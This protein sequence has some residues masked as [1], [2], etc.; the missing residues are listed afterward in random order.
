MVAGKNRMNKKRYEILFNQI[1]LHFI[2]MEKNKTIIQFF[3]WY[4]R[5][6]GR[7]WKQFKEAIPELVYMGFTAAWL[8]PAYKG[9]KGSRSEGYDVYD[10]YD[11]GEFDQKETVATGYGT[12]ADYIAACSAA[13]SAGLGIIVDV[14]LNHKGGADETEKIMVRKVDAANRNNFLSGPFE[15]EAFTRFT[16]PGRNKTYSDF[17]WDHRCFTGIDRLANGNKESAEENVIYSIINEYGEGWEKDVD[18]ANDNFD[19]LMFCDLEFRNPYVREELKKWIKWY[20]AKVPFQGVRL[21]AV[22][23]ISYAFLNE[24]IDYLRDELGPNMLVIGEYWLSDDLAILLK[25]SEDTE[26][27]M[28]LFD[29]P[30]HHNFAIAAEQKSGYD[31]RT[32]LDETLVSIKPQ[33]AITFADNHDTQPLQSLEEWVEEWFKPHAYAIILLRKNG[34]PCVFYGDLY[35]CEYTNGQNEPGKDKGVTIHA[36]PELPLLVKLR[37]SHAY[38]DQHDYFTAA[39]LIGW[40]RMG[41]FENDSKGCAVVLSNGKSSSLKMFVGTENANRVYVDFLQN[42]SDEIITDEE[43][44]GDF[45]VN[46]NSVSVWVL[47]E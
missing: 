4:T 31:L 7:F 46:E 42:R 16:F 34:Y 19:Y 17:V 30:Q 32:I 28:L 45:P 13:Q 33:V 1:L 3:E 10:L 26:D 37:E 11:L 18:G 9:M 47:K 29:A 41:S 40:V 5:K 43:G 22:K 36:V 20:H 35:G 24:W 44:T 15:V 23:H 12:A 39:N 25:Y 8:P 14:V 27:R 38:G 6:D 2:T 21:D